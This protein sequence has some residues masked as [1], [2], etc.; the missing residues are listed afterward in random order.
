MY[1]A[2]IYII[3]TER[4]GSNL[5]RLI[6]HAH[7]RICVP[8]PLHLMGYFG[9]TEAARGDLDDPARF[10]QLVDEILLLLKLHI[11]PWKTRISKQRI[12]DEAHPR[13]SIG[14]LG[15]LSEQVTDAHGKQR[16]GSKST[17]IVEYTDHA[18]RR[19]PDARFVLLVRDPRD[20]AAS[21]MRSVFSPC[22]PWITSELWRRQQ[23]VGLEVMDREGPDTVMLMKYEDLLDDP[24]G[25]VRRMCDFIG[26]AFEPEMLQ[27]HR[28]EEANHMA[29]MSESWV[30]ISRPIMSG[31]SG[32]YRRH[33]TQDQVRMVEAVCA[34][35]MERLGYPLDFPGETLSPSALRHLWFRAQDRAWTARI[36]ARALL[37]DSMCLRRWIR[38]AAMNAIDLRYRRFPPR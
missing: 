27:Y 37:K 16:W 12:L 4:S 10:E 36:E 9:P 20:V 6:L 3:G 21:S 33:L 26:E 19:D 17:F 11:R 35:L 31:N 29:P 14:V 7:S 13:S 1:E 23:T 24:E 32:K 28:K 30:N 15:A 2:P 34:P 38:D 5:L 18:L 25:E 22:H 8:H